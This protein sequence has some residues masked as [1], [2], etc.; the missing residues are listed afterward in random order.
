MTTTNEILERRLGLALDFQG[1]LAADLKQM[2]AWRNKWR[3]RTREWRDKTHEAVHAMRALRSE[4]AEVREQTAHLEKTLASTT[5]AWDAEVE[6]RSKVAR[7]TAERVAKVA[8][9]LRTQLEAAVKRADLAEATL[10]S[11]RAAVAKPALDK[12]DTR[13]NIGDAVPWSEAEAGALYYRPDLPYAFRG[14]TDKRQCLLD[15]PHDED[16]PRLLRGG[17]NPLS[18][19]L[20]GY[21][22]SPTGVLIA[23][24]LGTDP[25]A[26]RAAMREYLAKVG[27]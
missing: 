2:R 1:S 23:R 11:V 6:A 3:T 18:E 17:G 21:L 25:E 5:S 7:Q 14:V 13:P 8:T 24:D 9:D 12:E 22:S 10:E 20:G 16:L 26:W 19:L 15:G 4:L 27:K